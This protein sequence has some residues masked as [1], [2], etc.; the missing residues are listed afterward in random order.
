L[1]FPPPAGAGQGKAPQDRFIGIEQDNLATAGL[2]LEG[3][4]LQ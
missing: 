1:G 4:K 2:V 3:S